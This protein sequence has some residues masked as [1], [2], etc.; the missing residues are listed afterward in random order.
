MMWES[1]LPALGSHAAWMCTF[2]Q[3]LPSSVR[4][5]RSSPDGKFFAALG[6]DGSVR[7]YQLT[8]AMETLPL[9]SEL[10]RLLGRSYSQG[11]DFFGPAP[12]L[13]HHFKVPLPLEIGI[14]GISWRM[15]KG[16][17][18]RPSSA[19]SLDPCNCLLLTTAHG[20]CFIL[21]EDR[22]PKSV[23]GSLFSIHQCYYPP[24][25]VGNLNE[26]PS[27]PHSPDQ[28]AWWLEDV[29]IE[30]ITGQTSMLV[31][32][33]SSAL[34]AYNDSQSE[35]QV[36]R[37]SNVDMA[38]GT[39]VS[40]DP[41]VNVSVGWSK[42]SEIASAAVLL[43]GDVAVRYDTTT[44]LLHTFVLK[45]AA[46]EQS[47]VTGDFSY[48]TVK[49]SRP[50][51]SQNAQKVQV[52][53][54]L[55][56]I[57][58]G[59]GSHYTILQ[60]DP[61]S[62]RSVLTVVNVS[63]LY[64][65]HH[66][67]GVFFM[68]GEPDNQ[69]SLISGEPPRLIALRDA[70]GKGLFS[71]GSIIGVVSSPM[72]VPDKPVTIIGLSHGGEHLIFLTVDLSSGLY[73]P[74]DHL[75]IPSPEKFAS[76]ATYGSLMGLF[77]VGEGKDQ[78]TV[79]FVSPSNG[80]S[81]KEVTDVA[82][83][84]LVHFHKG[85]VCSDFGD[86]AYVN[87]DRVLMTISLSPTGERLISIQEADVLVDFPL[88]IGFAP[89]RTL[90][91]VL[92]D[93]LL[94]YCVTLS[95]LGQECWT[96]AASSPWPSHMPQAIG[97]E[98]EPTL[99]LAIMDELRMLL[100]SV[101]GMIFK[102]EKCYQ[103]VERLR[104]DLQ[105]I[106]D[107]ILA[108]RSMNYAATNLFSAL[109]M[110]AETESQQG[111]SLVRKDSLKYPHPRARLPRADGSGVST[112]NDAFSFFNEVEFFAGSDE[113]MASSLNRVTA[114]TGPGSAKAS[115]SETDRFEG[116]RTVTPRPSLNTSC[117][118]RIR[119]ATLEAARWLEGDQLRAVDSAGLKYLYF[120]RLSW[121][122]GASVSASSGVEYMAAYFSDAQE[123]LIEATRE[124]VELSA[125]T[126]AA[127]P[128]PMTW[129]KFGP[130]L[131][132][133]WI[134]NEQRL[135]ELLEEVARADFLVSSS[136]CPVSANTDPAMSAILYLIM[137]R[138]NLLKTLWKNR[139]DTEG[140]KMVCFLD[141][142]F[143]DESVRLVAVKNAFAALS[144]QR[145]RLS[146]FFFLLARR[147]EDAL[148]V[149]FERLH[150]FHLGYL[151]GR[152]MC[153]T[154]QYECMI[155]RYVR[156]NKRI[157]IC[158]RAMMKKPIQLDKEYLELV[159]EES[160]FTLDKAGLCLPL[161]IVNLR[162]AGTPKLS[163]DLL[164]ACIE[165]LCISGCYDLAAKLAS[166]DGER[167]KDET[168]QGQHLLMLKSLTATWASRWCNSDS[169]KYMAK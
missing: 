108:Y 43:L 114:T 39:I 118:G 59:G 68:L 33:G 140:S 37:L 155:A 112:S 145:L 92:P 57:Q 152:F 119:M 14:T 131:M 139:Q 144:K 113:D 64:S 70:E 21:A 151:I 38:S 58:D 124:L 6:T 54:S 20:P 141:K 162:G 158:L 10:G 36:I 32:E 30:E 97:A 49:A 127:S 15:Y 19:D 26:D 105:T 110:P 45:A 7:I 69:A 169:E 134:K 98:L 88:Y 76:A 153:D 149:C 104:N 115:G 129:A 27:L 53:G 2:A 67:P 101:D 142:D 156:D 82:T 25:N 63:S 48:V 135:R 95:E 74:T 117:I 42:S 61:L 163:E 41:L 86:Y 148:Q 143:E 78:V 79:K 91:V 84:P 8:I 138:R 60:H 72:E 96:R 85:G 11:L 87:K 35:L 83:V 62:L 147:L 107:T 17:A 123:L 80:D 161:A 50:L 71:L 164:C 125:P 18:Q 122:L 130:T 4:N 109:E 120:T 40:L 146:L 28:L 150:D 65:N 9:R 77:V 137:G 99:S 3:S 165:Q 47:E 159:R 29:E 103:D 154:P 1:T 121:S 128:T 34:I 106:P 66:W 166:S 44:N 102:L 55:I 52:S 46:G 31:G 73:Q 160:D 93:G 157:P 132:G 5:V 116:G 136:T 51:Y 13:L 90:Y 22:S 133:V 16:R 89:D 12:P 23:Y 24:G 94:T 56:A 167:D 168:V 111:L 75:Q 100:L 81:F 126:L